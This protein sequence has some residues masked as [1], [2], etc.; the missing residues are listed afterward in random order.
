MEDQIK[1]KR[2]PGESVNDCLKKNYQRTGVKKK[3]P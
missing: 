3:L 2:L 1:Q